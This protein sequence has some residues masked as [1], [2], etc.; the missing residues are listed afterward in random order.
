MGIVV[1]SA[2]G[3]DV[4]TSDSGEGGMTVG[5]LRFNEQPNRIKT[6]RPTNIREIARFM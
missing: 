2:A 4:G 5:W 3:V 6:A 1:P